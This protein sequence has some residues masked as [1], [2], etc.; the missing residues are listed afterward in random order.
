MPR[1]KSRANSAYG[2][3]YFRDPQI[4]NGP[5][6]QDWSFSSLV[7]KV[8]AQ[9]AANPR[10]GLP[11]DPNIVADQV[12][13]ANAIRCQSLGPAVSA[14]FVMEG[15]PAT[16][17]SFPQTA[18]SPRPRLLAA[19]AL[20]SKLNAGKGLLIEW[21]EQGFQSV[22][23]E[24]AAARA[25]VCVDCPKNN[26]GHF[27]KWFTVPVVNHFMK[28]AGKMNERKLTTSDD[29]KL[30]TCEACLCPMRGKV[31]VPMDLIKKHTPDG[32]EQQL[33]PRCWL[34]KPNA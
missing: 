15:G 19:A 9:R 26:P 27:T 8:V 32:V 1:L 31:W 25:K 2:G 5:P 4:N 33:D 30:G 6:L 29:E 28:L 3:F 23:P 18:G 11:T 24:A 17:P 14:Q 10:F 21:E 20:V 12:D 34:L 22:T 13:E 7:N 16:A